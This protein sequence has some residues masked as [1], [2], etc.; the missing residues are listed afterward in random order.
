MPRDE[1]SIMG[2]YMAKFDYSAYYR[3]LQDLKKAPDPSRLSR[4]AEPIAN[5]AAETNR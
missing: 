4:D 2:P 5:C 1:A 3:R